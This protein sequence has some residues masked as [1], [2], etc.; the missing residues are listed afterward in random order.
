MFI[1]ISQIESHIIYDQ[2]IVQIS[3]TAIILS[4][5]KRS[6]LKYITITDHSSAPVDIKHYM[7]DN[8]VIILF[9]NLN[10]NIK[11]CLK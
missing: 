11:S 5:E 4:V 1:V 9:I 6:T 3:I 8:D 2:F 10:L 7:Q